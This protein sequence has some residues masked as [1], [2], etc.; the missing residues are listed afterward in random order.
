M[1]KRDTELC[2][3]DICIREKGFVMPDKQSKSKRLT[4]RLAADELASL[5]VGCKKLGVGKSALARELFALAVTDD[6]G[7]YI[8]GHTVSVVWVD[9]S[10]AVA[11]SADTAK[12]LGELKRWGTN[13]DQCAHALNIIKSNDWMTP[14]DAKA[15]IGSALE[16][17]DGI[18][19]VRSEILTAIEALTLQVDHINKHARRR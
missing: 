16:R 17:L 14:S 2:S 8:A 19:E 12:L 9:R 15:H 10:S 13:I 18:R 3:P 1:G 4:I 11:I 6:V 5:E 7:E